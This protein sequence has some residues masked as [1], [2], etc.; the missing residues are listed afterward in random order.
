[1]IKKILFGLGGIIAIILVV[2][3]FQADTYL[4]ERTA[5]ISATPEVVFKH[6]TD[7]RDWQRSNPWVLEDPTATAA[8][9][10]ES[11][12][13]GSTYSWTGE[14][15]GKGT[16]TLVEARPFSYAKASLHF[17]EPFE[18][19]ATDEYFLE[20]SGS[21]TKVL[22]RMSGENDYMGKLFGLF[23]SMDAMIGGNF[24][25]EFAL[26]NKNLTAAGR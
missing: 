15:V 20:P 10:G 13:V 24:E 19:M 9:T 17:K 16:A 18:N 12:A 8:F 11:G 5:T 26:M 4:I 1:M 2:A 14:Q 25:K 21:G 23:M 6:I 22:H 3:A 7:Q